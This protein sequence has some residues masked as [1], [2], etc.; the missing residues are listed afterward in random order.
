M[1]VDWGTN[2]IHG[3]QNVGCL[4][5][6]QCPTSFP[7]PC[8]LSASFNMSLTYNMG[9]IIGRELRAYYNAGVHNSLDTWSPTI[10]INRD[11]RWGMLTWIFHTRGACAFSLWG[12]L[13]RSKCRIPGRRSARGGVVRDGL[14]SGSSAVHWH[15][16]SCAVGGHT[17]TL[18]GVRSPTFSLAFFLARL[19]L[20]V[21]IFQ[22]PSLVRV[23]TVGGIPGTQSKATTVLNGTMLMSK[24]RLTT[25]PILTVSV[26]WCIACRDNRLTLAERVQPQPGRCLSRRA[27]R[28]VSCVHVCIRNLSKDSFLLNFCFALQI[29]RSMASPLVATLHSTKL[30]AKTGALRAT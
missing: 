20:S 2:A 17:Q 7:A 18:L 9:N 5:T 19:G 29:M 23:I 25:W 11:P 30:S 12:R 24:C 15:R 6:S 28:S 16:K 8:S 13:C 10:N 22:E 27:K 21:K 14:H 4:N 26:T 1:L 3:M